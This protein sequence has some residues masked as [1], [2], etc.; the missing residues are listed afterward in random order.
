MLAQA[1]GFTCLTCIP[2]ILF[3]VRCMLFIICFCAVFENENNGC[4]VFCVLPNQP[5][6]V[7][8]SLSLLCILKIKK[9]AYGALRQC[10]FS[11]IVGIP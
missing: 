1:L 8:S 7:I 6:V 9:Y 3:Y 4:S 11:Q 5:V 10:S 2:P